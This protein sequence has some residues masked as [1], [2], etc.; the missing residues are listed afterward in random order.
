MAD[1]KAQPGK[2][3]TPL[4]SKSESGTRAG[5]DSDERKNPAM[6]SPEPGRK[7]PDK[8]P[9][10]PALDTPPAAATSATQPPEA[11]GSADERTPAE[12]MPPSTVGLGGPASKP[13]A[14]PKSASGDPGA[15][16]PAPASV[17]ATPAG[18]R[19]DAV[20]VPKGAAVG[21]KGINERN[22]AQGDEPKRESA[23]APPPSGANTEGRRTVNRAA[24]PPTGIKA[25]GSG[26]AGT[27]RP[28]ADARNHRRGRS[29]AATLLIILLLLIAGAALGIWAGPRIA[30][31]LPAG[32]APVAEWLSPQDAETETRLATLES[33]MAAG[34]DALRAEI[35]A[36]DTSDEIEARLAGLEES[37]GSRIESLAAELQSLDGTETRQR[38]AQLETALEGERETLAS[39]SDQLSAATG[40]ASAEIDTYQAALA[41][42]RGEVQES[43][44]QVAALSRR[45][46][47]VAAQAA[48]QVDLARARVAEIEAE[49]AAELDQATIEAALAQIRSALASGTPFSD[50][51]TRLAEGPGMPAGLLNAASEGVPAIQS[52]RDRFPQAANAAIQASVQSQSAEGDVLDRLGGFFRSQVA[53]RSLEPREGDDT[54]AVLSRM[55]AALREG[56][57]D[58]ALAEAEALPPAATAAMSDWLAAAQ[59]RQE[60]VASFETL[61]AELSATN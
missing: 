61:Q 53:S 5:P 47:E 14:P 36:E 8:R 49:A 51:A 25:T 55:E 29:P 50:A 45:I 9:D 33:D 35:E 38:L 22:P 54:D 6:T 56:D 40:S 20:A 17:P 21:P 60:A 24:T 3:G 43:V 32:M 34:F 15:G 58:T 30:P 28:P 59:S 52:L 23:A 12:K 41:G 2:D 44:A 18:A 19:P 39:L 42:L 26:N 48:Q 31:H 11:E 16:A 27:T 37:L 46:D 57:L 1:R 7:A 4:E 10:A 13:A